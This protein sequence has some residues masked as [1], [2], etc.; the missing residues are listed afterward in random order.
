MKVHVIE[1][2]NKGVVQLKRPN[3]HCPAV[4]NSVI[5]FPSGSSLVRKVRPQSNSCVGNKRDPSK[6]GIREAVGF[7][8]ESETAGKAELEYCSSKSKSSDK[9]C[10]RVEPC[11]CR[12]DD[13]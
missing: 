8:I 4:P 1:T 12:D 6:V 7:S 10:G 2:Y 5:S 3:L 13:V 9:A 11:S